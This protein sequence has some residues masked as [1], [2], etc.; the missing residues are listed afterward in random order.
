[1]IR[2]LVTAA[3]LMSAAASAEPQ[4]ALT[5]DDLPSHGVKPAGISR[6]QIAEEAIA[7]L[8]AGGVPP[9]MGLVNAALIE[10]EPDAAPVLEAWRAGGNLLGNHTYSHPGL[11]KIGAAAFEA[12]TIKNEAVLAKAAGG[13]DWHWFRYPFLD[14]G[15]DNAERAE[16]RSFLAGRGYRIAAVTVALNDWDYPAPYARCLA[17]NDTAAIAALETMYLKRAEE[18]LSYSRALA[19]AAFGHDIAYVQL[20]HIGA[21]QVHML[22]KLIALYKAKGVSFVSLEDAEK[23][24]YYRGYTDPTLPAPQSLESA[25]AG[26][27]LPSAPDNRNAE[28]DAICK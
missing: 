23:D 9:T 12:D 10:G 6:P 20:L 3:L 14:E 5:F 7:A 15:K 2:P 4:V 25:A 21:F 16:I 26:H 8:K 27:P 28:L 22:P 19:N 1:M 17:R 13:S 11:S 18:G 24:P